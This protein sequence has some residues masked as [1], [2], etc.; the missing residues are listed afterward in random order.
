MQ[1]KKKK[2]KLHIKMVKVINFMVHVFIIIKKLTVS[3]LVMNIVLI[4][5]C[6]ALKLKRELVTI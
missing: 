4:S 5:K 2:K 6:K 1:P 3:L